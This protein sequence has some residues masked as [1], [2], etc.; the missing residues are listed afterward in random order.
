M[1]FCLRYGKSI[2]TLEYPGVHHSIDVLVSKLLKHWLLTLIGHMELTI[3][4]VIYTDVTIDPH[5]CK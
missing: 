4:M 5:S 2:T 3:S 1:V